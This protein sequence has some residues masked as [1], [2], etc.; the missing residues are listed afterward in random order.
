LFAG[1]SEHADGVG[2][3]VSG[4]AGDENGHDERGD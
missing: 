1:F 4:A 3:D 2:T